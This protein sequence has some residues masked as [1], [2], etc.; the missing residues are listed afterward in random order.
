[1]KESERN[2]KQKVMRLFESNIDNNTSMDYKP[3][4]IIDD[5]ESRYIEH[6]S[7]KDKKSSMKKNLEKI[8]IH[9]PYMIDGIKK[10]GEWKKHLKISC[11]NMSSTDSNENVPCYLVM[12]VIAA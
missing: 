12:K 7:E 9:L 8:R 5:F 11:K 3:K 10:P 2:T 6:K 1:M 4:K